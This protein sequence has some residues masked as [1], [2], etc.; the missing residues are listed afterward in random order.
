MRSNQPFNINTGNMF[1]HRFIILAA[2]CLCSA[3]LF[4][5]R[6]TTKKQAI[7]IT[8]SYKPVLR[9]AVKIN[10]SGSQLAADTSKP[11]LLYNIPSQNLF[12]AYQPITLKPLALQQDTNLYLGNRR[13]VKAG[14][15]S[16]STPYI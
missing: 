1:Q 2:A 8:S 5:Q 16:L 3:N 13:Y 11:S 15:G 9:N 14:F 7:D 10:F 12:Y 6:D 4:A